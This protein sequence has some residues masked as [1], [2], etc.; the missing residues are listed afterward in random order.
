MKPI[1]SPAAKLQLQFLLGVRFLTRRAGDPV[2]DSLFARAKDDKTGTVADDAQ[3]VA[4]AVID[5]VISRIQAAF[6]RRHGA[7]LPVA[8]QKVRGRDDLPPALQEAARR[9]QLAL[10]NGE[11]FDNVVYVQDAHGTA[12]EVEKTIFHELYG[13]AATAALFDDESVDKQNALL[14]AIGGGDGLYRLA[15][16]NQIDLRTYADGLAADTSLTDQRRARS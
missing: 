2:P 11:F 12:E 1:L 5:A 13:H 15:A 9:Q 14:K 4:D 8:I 16:A 7:A 10:G 3:P 6:A